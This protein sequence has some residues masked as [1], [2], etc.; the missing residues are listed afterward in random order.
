MLLM[1]RRYPMLM[2]LEI[3]QRICHQLKVPCKQAVAWMEGG[4]V[5]VSVYASNSDNVDL[6]SKRDAIFQR[7]VE[8]SGLLGTAE[9]ESETPIDANRL[10]P[11]YVR[12]LAVSNGEA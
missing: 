3:E 11:E 6:R 5:Q 1:D 7:W 12:C 9:L 10:V 4:R 8:E 2:H